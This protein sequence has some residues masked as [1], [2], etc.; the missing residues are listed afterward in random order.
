M[1]LLVQYKTSA[2]RVGPEPVSE[3]EVF[4]RGLKRSSSWYVEGMSTTRA[5]SAMD[6]CTKEQHFG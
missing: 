6:G 3:P 2:N 1:Y 4:G 5:L